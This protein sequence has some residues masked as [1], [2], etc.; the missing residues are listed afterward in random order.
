MTEILRAT[1]C[2][3]TY[4]AK[5]ISLANNFSSDIA[6][7]ADMPMGSVQ[8]IWRNVT[9]TPNG[10]VTL[11]CSNLPEEEWFFDG[12]EING[13]VYNINSAQGGN[14]WLRERL[15]FRYLQARYVKNGIAG[16]TLDIVALG[17]KT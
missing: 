4:L 11:Y 3:R 15:A 1:N 16:G 10:I 13:A 5:G 2:N 14:I 8:L 9:G 6:D 7:F 12:G 17:K